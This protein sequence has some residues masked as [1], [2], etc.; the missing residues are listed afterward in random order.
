[1]GENDS[2]QLELKK[3]KQN[4]KLLL[5]TSPCFYGFDYPMSLLELEGHLDH[6]DGE[7]AVIDK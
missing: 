5:S 7:G 1:M 6:A 3:K 2:S 4:A